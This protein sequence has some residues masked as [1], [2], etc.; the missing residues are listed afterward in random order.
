MMPATICERMRSIGAWTTRDG[1]F[2]CG[3]SDQPAYPPTS[4]AGVFA[5][6][7]RKG[8]ISVQWSVSPAGFR[9]PDDGPATPDFEEL[10]SDAMTVHYKASGFRNAEL[11]KLP[12]SIEWEGVRESDGTRL[13][14]DWSGRVL[15]RR[16]HS[17]L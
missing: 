13:K 9:C 3:V 16:V 4:V 11:L 1:T 10:P 2:G 5:A 6:N 15:L 17:R 12:V 14:L 7:Q 8:T